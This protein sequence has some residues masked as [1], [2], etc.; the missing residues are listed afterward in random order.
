MSDLMEQEE[1]QKKLDL[2]GLTDDQKIKDIVCSLIGHSKIQTACFG[3]FY[4]AR[5]G[6]QLGDA[7]ASTYEDAPNVVIVGH[8]CDV[9]EANYSKCTWQDKFMCPNPFEER[10]EK[11]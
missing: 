5:C 10:K 3:Y 7:L 1:L 8:K 2:L 9:C 4:C 11:G 6:G